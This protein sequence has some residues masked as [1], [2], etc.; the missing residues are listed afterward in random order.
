MPESRSGHKHTQKGTKWFEPESQLLFLFAVLSSM[1]TVSASGSAQKL[2]FHLKSSSLSSSAAVASLMSSSIGCW[3]DGFVVGSDCSALAGGKFAR[4]CYFS[5]H[6][7]HILLS[8]FTSS[9]TSMLPSAGGRIS[10]DAD[11]ISGTTHRCNPPQVDTEGNGAGGKQRS[12]RKL[13]PHMARAT[14]WRQGWA[15]VSM[16]VVN[17]PLGVC[18]TTA[19]SCGKHTAWKP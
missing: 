14:A 1:K 6:Y 8:E 11:L 4:C 3:I 2:V 19:T 7:H 15:L 5:Q 16:I 10:P 9:W 17:C 18:L 12:A 13:E